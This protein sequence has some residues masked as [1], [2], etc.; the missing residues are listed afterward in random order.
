MCYKKSGRMGGLNQL[1][2]WHVK[3]PYLPN[4]PLPQNFD[5]LHPVITKKCISGLPLMSF[6]IAFNPSILFEFPIC[7]S[8]ITKKV[9]ESK[10]DALEIG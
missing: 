10:L 8:I 4:T 3:Y 9:K 5:R 6:I 2:H 7:V 1:R